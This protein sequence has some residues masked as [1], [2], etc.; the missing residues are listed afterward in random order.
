MAEAEE[1]V[2]EAARAWRAE[3]IFIF[4]IV[5]LFYP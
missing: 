2:M 4:A 1:M 3:L 5:F